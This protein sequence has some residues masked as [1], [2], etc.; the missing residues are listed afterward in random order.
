MNRCPVSRGYLFPNRGQSLRHQS[1][2]ANPT[3]TFLLQ[4][5]QDHV[6]PARLQDPRE[7]PLATAGNSLNSAYRVL[8]SKAGTG[9]NRLPREL[10][11]PLSTDMPRCIA[12]HKLA[13][14]VHT[15]R[16]VRKASSSRHESEVK[17]ENAGLD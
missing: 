11:R 17:Y 1:L 9:E 15:F 5:M 6:N 4:S 8:M 13:V 12:E 2:G 14:L 16:S 10:C 3:D 7:S